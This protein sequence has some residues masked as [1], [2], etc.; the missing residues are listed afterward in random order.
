MK[1][2]PQA[3]FEGVWL[4]CGEGVQKCLPQMTVVVGWKAVQTVVPLGG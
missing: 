2:R 4:V 1:T 3:E